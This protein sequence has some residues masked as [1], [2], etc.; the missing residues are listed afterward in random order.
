MGRLYEPTAEEQS[1]RNE[2][3]QLSIELMSINIGLARCIDNS[4]VSEL[5][6]A[7][8]RLKEFLGKIDGKYLEFF[9]RPLDILHSIL[10]TRMYFNKTFASPLYKYPLNQMRMHANS[11]PELR[12]LHAIYIDAIESSLVQEA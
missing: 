12:N 5:P 1:S 2:Y 4:N 3:Y 8:L 6:Q 10:I 7:I 11:E 9:R